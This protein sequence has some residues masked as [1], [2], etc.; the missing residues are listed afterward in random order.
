M[1]K[2]RSPWRIGWFLIYME[3]ILTFDVSVF[4]ISQFNWHVLLHAFA[5]EA[6]I[7]SSFIYLEYWWDSLTKEG[8]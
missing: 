5:V 4:P 6:Y 3:L 1:K 2:Q 8:E 7:L